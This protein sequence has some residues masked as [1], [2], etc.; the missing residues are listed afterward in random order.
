[1]VD[2]RDGARTL[3]ADQ[4]NYAIMHWLDSAGKTAVSFIPTQDQSTGG[5]GAYAGLASALNACCSAQVVAV[6]FVSTVILG[7]AGGAGPY[8]T[9][10]D[11]GSLLSR[12]AVTNAPQRISLVGPKAAIFLPDTVTINLANTEIIALQSEVMSLAG[13]A[14]GNAQGPFRRGKRQKASGS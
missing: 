5:A 11:R 6:Q 7:G 12:N 2:A 10:M 9:V 1:V 3:M 14:L 13:D 4:Y 8:M